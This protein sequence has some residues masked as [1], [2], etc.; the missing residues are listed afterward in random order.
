[1]HVNFLISQ[2]YITLHAFASNTVGVSIIVDCIKDAIGNDTRKYHVHTFV[3]FFNVHNIQDW[4]LG[5]F[6]LT[7]H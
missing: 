6:L 3:T 1:M 4:T 2:Y 5:Y 7:L